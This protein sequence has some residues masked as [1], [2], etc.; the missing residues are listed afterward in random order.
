MFTGCGGNPR[1]PAGSADNHAD[2]PAD[3]EAERKP[4]A[5]GNTEA[6]EGTDQ[7][8]DEKASQDR[9]ELQA[10][11]FDVGKGDCILLT[12]GEDNVLLDAGYEE[13][14]RS[15]AKKLKSMGIDSLDAMIITHYDKDHVGGAAE[16]ADQIPVDIFYLPDYEG[17]EDKGG[18]L[19][20]Y[21]ERKGL[22]SVRVSEQ[23]KLA[24]GDAE[25]EVDPAL[26]QYD[27]Q[28]KNDND[29]SLIV[30][31]FYK[32]D[33]WLLPGDIEK[34]AIDLWLRD[35]E[36]EY[37]V[38]KYPHHGKK[39]KNYSEFID[40]VS[41]EIAV[42]TDSDEDHASK[43]VLKKQDEDQVETYRSSVDGTITIK[44]NG[45]GQFDISTEK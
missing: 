37:N 28:E 29:A 2:N 36:Q 12:M 41:P 44:G 9:G 16:I 33:E 5:G 38:L 18:D 32:E 19:L 30:K 39:E 11:F 40:N 4:A 43:K 8:S 1:E 26:I 17:D 42:I 24:L 22:E 6:A 20:D 14:W 15:V 27:L 23:K 10:V 7:E 45:T 31:I 35:R 34:D 21:I 25:I 13:T 3:S